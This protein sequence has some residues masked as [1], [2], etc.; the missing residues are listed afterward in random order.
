MIALK[1]NRPILRKGN[2]YFTDYDAAWLDEALE[3]AAKR[4]DMP[5]LFKEEIVHSILIFLEEICP[6][7]VLP[8]EVLLTR[9]RQMLHTIGL[10]KIA[11]HFPEVMPPVQVDL[12]EIAERNPLPL[13]FF[14]DLR[15]EIERLQDMGL[16]NYQF[17]GKRQCAKALAAKIRWSKSSEETLEDLNA[18]L[19]S[20]Q[21]IA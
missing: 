18:Y 16:S 14:N 21:A 1:N 8:I 3:N 12:D 7:N 2:C 13:F 11:S 9:I 17:Q 20:F 15:Q 6:L 10:S 5:I 19:H 4:A